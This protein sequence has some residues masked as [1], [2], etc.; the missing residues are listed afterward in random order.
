M[1]CSSGISSTAKPVVAGLGEQATG[2][3][4]RIPTRCALGVVLEQDRG[5]VDLRHPRVSEQRPF[6][7]LD[8]DL[9]QRA[10]GD[11]LERIYLRA[12]TQRRRRAAQRPGSAPRVR[13]R[14]ASCRRSA[15]RTPGSA[16]SGSP[17]RWPRSHAHRRGHWRDPAPP[18]RSSTRASRCRHQTPKA[19]IL[20][21][22][23]AIESPPPSG[24]EQLPRPHRGGRRSPTRRSRR[25][26]RRR[27]RRGASR[28]ERRRPGSV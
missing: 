7:R 3:G 4:V 14:K 6:R 26:R 17:P 8:V 18:R 13:R 5:R 21:P 15:R 28:A 24:A 11:Q 22:R 2:V 27:Q 20:A 1:P 23:S 25:R 12:S 10:V 19:P 9:D 16:P